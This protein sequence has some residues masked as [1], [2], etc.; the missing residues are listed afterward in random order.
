MYMRRSFLS[1]H[2]GV[3]PPLNVTEPHTAVFFQTHRCAEIK[4]EWWA[5][6]KFPALLGLARKINAS[7]TEKKNRANARKTKTPP[8]NIKTQKHRKKAQKHTKKRGGK[9]QIF[10]RAHAR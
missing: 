3:S 8:K 7:N 2:D 10:F 4:F 5:E 6:R 1:N 9:R